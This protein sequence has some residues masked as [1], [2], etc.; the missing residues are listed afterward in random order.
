MIDY[1]HPF[2]M[3]M[4]KSYNISRDFFIKADEVTR[5]KGY[6]NSELE[7]LFLTS[8]FM[9]MSTD[10]EIRNLLDKIDSSC[11]SEKDK[12]DY[13]CYFDGYLDIVRKTN[14]DVLDKAK[15]YS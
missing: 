8:A 12:I 10:L 14:K 5:S 2:I 13:I 1:N 15:F 6:R 3:E 7:D 9:L 4:R 11:L